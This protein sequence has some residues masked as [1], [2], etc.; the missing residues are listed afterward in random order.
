MFIETYFRL[1]RFL[2]ELQKLSTSSDLPL[3]VD[4]PV[5]EG[6]PVNITAAHVNSDRHQQGYNYNDITWRYVVNSINSGPVVSCLQSVCQAVGYTQTTT[7]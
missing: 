2:H 5:E 4:T 3:C 1:Q 7:L 6:Q